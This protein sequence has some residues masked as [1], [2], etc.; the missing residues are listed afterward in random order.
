MRIEDARKARRERR[1]RLDGHGNDGE[2]R[3]QSWFVLCALIPLTGGG[4]DVVDWALGG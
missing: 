3:L 2:R 1:T 4:Q